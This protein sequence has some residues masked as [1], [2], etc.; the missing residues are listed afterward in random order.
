MTA[1]FV[2]EVDSASSFPMACMS[3][4]VKKTYAR[5]VVSRTSFLESI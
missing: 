5:Y 4:D 2:I 1:D 3:P